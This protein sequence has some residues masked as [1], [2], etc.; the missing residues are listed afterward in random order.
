M[1]LPSNKDQKP[2]VLPDTL[3]DLALLRASDLDLGT[4]V[5]TTPITKDGT[6]T[7]VQKEDDELQAVEESLKNSYEYVRS[8]RNVVR[9]KDRGDVDVQGQR[10]ERAREEL[11]NV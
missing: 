2:F 5:P 4:L 8:A 7:Q 3:Q 9:I 10:I 11:A 6:Q 1:P